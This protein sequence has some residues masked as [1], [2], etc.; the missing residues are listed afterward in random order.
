MYI[1]S[2]IEICKKKNIILKFNVKYKIKN[3]IC[4]YN[5]FII[6]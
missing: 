6:N 5:L 3:N 1:S 2:H 4:E